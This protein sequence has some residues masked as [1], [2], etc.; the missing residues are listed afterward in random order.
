MGRTTPKNHNIRIS[1]NSEGTFSYTNIYGDTP[2]D[3]K[4][5]VVINGDRICWLLDSSIVERKFQIDFGLINPFD[6]GQPITM[7]GTDFI[8]SAKVVFPVNYPRDKNLKYSVLLG[9]GWMDDPDVVP[10]EVDPTPAI[11]TDG[12]AGTPDCYISWVDPASRMAIQL[13]HGTMSAHAGDSVTWEWDST[14]SNPRPFTLVF[15]SPLPPGW[16][17]VPNPVNFIVMR[18]GAGFAAFKITTMDAAGN[19]TSATGTLTI[20]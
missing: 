9:N 19:D 18:P 3:S 17:G 5:L 1:V 11:L 8:K 13:T 6:I 14:Q 2:N 12:L 15:T 4:R 10:V 7:R 20:T 16:A